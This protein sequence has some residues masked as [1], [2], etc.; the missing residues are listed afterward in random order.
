L[1]RK[2]LVLVTLSVCACDLEESYCTHDRQ[3]LQD[4][5]ECFAQQGCVVNERNYSWIKQRL[6]RCEELGL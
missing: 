6:R 1:K 3:R 4:M 5:R 2:I